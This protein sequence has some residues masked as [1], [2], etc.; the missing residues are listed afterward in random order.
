MSLEF[1]SEVGVD[2]LTEGKKDVWEKPPDVGEIGEGGAD[3]FLR[4]GTSLE[5]LSWVSAFGSWVDTEKDEAEALAVLKTRREALRQEVKDRKMSSDERADHDKAKRKAQWVLQQKERQ[6]AA[7]AEKQ[8]EK[9]ARREYQERE[10]NIRALHERAR[11]RDRRKPQHR[12]SALSSSA[13]ARGAASP[14]PEASP[15]VGTAE[16][17][18]ADDDLESPIAGIESPV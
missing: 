4:I 11:Q 9:E 2:A 6:A 18:M 12:S 15:L 8:R 1:N 14:P 13:Q 10:A 16:R 17:L 3:G 5:I 7:L